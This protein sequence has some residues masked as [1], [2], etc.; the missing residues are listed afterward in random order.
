MRVGEEAK[1]LLPPLAYCQ[2]LAGY[3]TTLKVKVGMAR[4]RKPKK[5]IIRANKLK[6]ATLPPT[7]NDNDNSSGRMLE[8]YE[9]TYEQHLVEERDDQDI[10]TDDIT[11]DLSTDQLER[12]RLQSKINPMF[13]YLKSLIR[14]F[15]IYFK[16]RIEILYLTAGVNI[17]IRLN[18][19]KRKSWYLKSYSKTKKEISHIINKLAGLLWF[20][21]QCVSISLLWISVFLVLGFLHM[22]IL[23]NNFYVVFRSLAEMQFEPFG[24][25]VLYGFL[26]LC[27]WWV[28][29][30][31][32]HLDTSKVGPNGKAHIA[33]AKEKVSNLFN[34]HL[35]Q[36]IFALPIIASFL[37]LALDRS[38]SFSKGGS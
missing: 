37:V 10:I 33:N 36:A 9:N 24:F 28:Q 29:Q 23:A 15:I 18:P 30:D 3:Q 21:V 34:M 11:D 1:K 19:L 22:V 25:I 13:A 8:T 31:L 27:I 6:V 38:M 5:N 7:M 16:F 4:K 17:N 32:L 20:C 26:L 35:K 12:G 2:K 14:L